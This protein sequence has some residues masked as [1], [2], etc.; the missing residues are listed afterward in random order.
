MGRAWLKGLVGLTDLVQELAGASFEID[1][2]VNEIETT[3]VGSETL[4]G[5]P[6]GSAFAFFAFGVGDGF[7][8]LGAIELSGLEP[9][10]QF[11]RCGWEE[12]FLSFADGGQFGGWEGVAVGEEGGSGLAVEPVWAA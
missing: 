12:E 7:G 6:D 10:S 11:I 4:D 5:M 3:S 2:G 1:A 9:L 8:G